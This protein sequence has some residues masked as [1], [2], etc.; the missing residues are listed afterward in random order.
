MELSLI[1][2]REIVKLFLMLLM[3][4]GLVK[5]G[6]LESG[7]AKTV[8]VLHVYLIT[9]CMI[10][11]SFQIDV[12]A[13]VLAGLAYTFLV[14][15]GVH[16][17]YLLFTVLFK[18]VFRLEL[19][20]QLSVVYTNAGILVIPLI[21]AI[22]GPEY[23]VYSCGFVTVQL[24]LLWTHAR[25]KISGE[26]KVPWK[27][28]LLNINLISIV[29]GAAL[30]AARIRLPALAGETLTSVG[31]MMG[32]LGMMMA[33][34]IIADIPLK[35]VFAVPRNYLATA[36]RL[37]VYPLMLL[38]VFK[39]LRLD[40]LVPDGK[41][42]LLIVYLASITP[43]CTTLTSIAQLY[44]QDTKRSSV[45]YVLTTTLSVVTIPLMIGVFSAVI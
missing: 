2:L 24:M 1:L 12:T 5:A 30:F 23:V 11:Q 44:N 10:I 22:L 16:I 18:R 37:L 43:A 33:G 6:F 29:A 26:K 14:S 40:A 32:P 21:Q 31:S 3:G 27:K 19:M 39:V 38:A 42:L 7:E 35:D 36:L 34:M 41:T 15:V 17:L 8:S 25:V 45:L 20:E 4:Y 13:Q 9:P 28:A